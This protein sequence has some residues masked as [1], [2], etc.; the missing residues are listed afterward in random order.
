VRQTGPERDAESMPADTVSIGSVEL[1]F[2]LAVSIASVLFLGLVLLL[3]RRIRR[4]RFCGKQDPKSV[5][6]MYSLPGEGPPSI[7]SRTERAS[8]RR[9]R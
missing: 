3:I 2:P 5:G 4:P 1:P 6:D 8:E 7:P 9:P